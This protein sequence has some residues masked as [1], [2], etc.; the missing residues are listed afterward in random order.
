[1]PGYDTLSNLLQL[2]LIQRKEEG[3]EVAAIAGKVAAT[4]ASGDEAQLQAVYDEVSALPVAGGVSY[5]EPSDLA[6]IRALRLPG[7]LGPVGPLRLPGEPAYDQFLGAWLGRCAGCALGKPLEAAAFMSGAAGNPGWKNVYLWFKEAG[8][9]PIHGYTPGVSPFGRALG[10]VQLGSQ[11]SQ[12]GNIRFMESDDDIRYTVL[13]LSL[14]EE[15]GLDW[16]TWDVG[17][18]W[19]RSLTFDQVFTAEAQAYL[20]FALVSSRLEHWAGR[21]PAD[22]QKRLEWVGTYRNPYRE[23][24]GAQIRADGLAYGA[25]GNPELAAEL[26]WRDASLSH[27]KNGIYGEMFVA[28]MIAAAFV[29]TDVE[30]IIRIGLSEIPATSRLYHDVERAMA[31]AK[32]AATELDLVERL[33]EAFGHYNCVHTINNAALVVAALLFAGD[34]FEKAITTAV[35]GG[36]DTD[37]NGATVG[38]ITGARLGAKALPEIWTAPLSDTVYAG[39]MG[40]HP[41]AISECARRSE[42]VWRRLSAT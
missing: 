9:W 20:N 19:Q 6:G 15:K 32:V 40:F 41:I 39:V 5:R 37:C 23:W 36:W 3:C 25:A 22:W 2:E 17:W 42:A 13:G 26:A 14:L 28:A 30:T 38:S 31:I 27:V 8:A 21:V 7:P 35:L 4:V 11:A 34:D 16:N 24:I 33:W 1:M 10:L 12:W 29:E 18:L